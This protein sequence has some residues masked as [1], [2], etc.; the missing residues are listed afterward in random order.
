M[1]DTTLGLKSFAHIIN[2]VDPP[3]GSDLAVA[4]PVTF[5]SNFAA[6]EAFDSSV[7]VLELLSAHSKCVES[8][9]C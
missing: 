2:P 7:G 5:A 4:Q 3:P 8:C 9:H 6:A 1:S